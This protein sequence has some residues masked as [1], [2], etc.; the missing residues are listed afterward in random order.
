M[1]FDR[2]MNHLP[3]HLSPF[4]Q[5]M[6]SSQIAHLRVPVPCMSHYV[7]VVCLASQ[8]SQLGVPQCPHI[9]A[10]APVW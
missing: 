7:Y 6:P 4:M 10:S 1:S 8:L 3:E 5:C 9:P 2:A